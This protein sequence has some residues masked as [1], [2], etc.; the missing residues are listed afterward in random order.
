M[1]TLRRDFKMA[2]VMTRKINTLTL[3]ARHKVDAN[4]PI[5][6]WRERVWIDTRERLRM[7]KKMMNILMR[8]LV[9]TRMN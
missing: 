7:L 1:S 8:R 2:E 6:R 3:H 4:F 5:V 9:N